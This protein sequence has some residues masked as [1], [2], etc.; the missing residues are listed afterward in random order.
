MASLCSFTAEWYPIV[1]V[2]ICVPRPLYPFLSLRT[3]TLFPRLG[4]CSAATSDE[5]RLSFQMRVLT[6]S[7]Y[8]PRNGTY[9][10]GMYPT[11]ILHMV[12]L[13]F[14]G[15]STLFSILATSIC[16]PTNSA[17]RFF[18][19]LHI[20]PSIYFFVDFLMFILTSVSKNIF[21]MFPAS[22]IYRFSLWSY[23]SDS[24]MFPFAK[25]TEHAVFLQQEAYDL[26]LSLFMCYYHVNNLRLF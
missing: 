12:A 22:L 23:G 18:P 1:C 15:V 14:K 4:Y 19:F 2:Y 25:T 10:P 13:V 11:Y 16:I 20:L 24:G 17:G 6:F 7:G 9:I 3:L 5:V 26:R 21:L 8:M